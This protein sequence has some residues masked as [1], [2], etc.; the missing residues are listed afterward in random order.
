MLYKPYFSPYSGASRSYFAS[1]SCRISSSQVV[2]FTSFFLF[3][4]APNGGAQALGPERGAFCRA[5]APVAWSP[6][7]GSPARGPRPRS[8]TTKRP[9]PHHNPHHRPNTD[10]KQLVL[11]ETALSPLNQHAL[12]DQVR[13]PSP[14][15]PRFWLSLA[16]ISARLLEVYT[17]FNPASLSANVHH[18]SPTPSRLSAPT[19]QLELAFGLA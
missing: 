11:I 2:R 18:Q 14:C 10:P 17:P 13:L 1:Q 8:N 5:M 3:C 6:V 12:L 15:A 7:L 4:K 16:L 9:G 19:F